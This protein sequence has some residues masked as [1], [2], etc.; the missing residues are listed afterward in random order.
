MPPESKS[1]SDFQ[2]IIS[3]EMDLRDAMRSGCLNGF[4]VR[5][6]MVQKT[7]FAERKFNNVLIQKMTAQNASFDEFEGVEVQFSGS[8]VCKSSFRFAEFD[9]LNVLNCAL[10]QCDFSN[11]LIQN[12][13][14]FANEMQSPCFI[15][16]KLVKSQFQDTNIYGAV[17]EHAFLA[18]CQFTSANGGNP[19]M[20]RANFHRSMVID[21]SLKDANLFAA[22]FSDA[23]LIRVDLR[24]ANLFQA[25]FRG[26]VMIDCMVHP[27]DLRDALR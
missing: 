10:R 6:F 13:A 18:Q 15:N 19:E 11:S 14:F 9:K 27:D 24:G 20:T 26:A 7:S 5:N 3:S 22:N 17:F 1:L 12:S 25:D 16:A 21:S 8:D 23:I 4:A 2:N